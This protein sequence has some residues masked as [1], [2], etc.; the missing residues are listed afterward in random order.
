MAQI[1]PALAK[2]C[3]L[4]GARAVLISGAV[5]NPALAAVAPWVK[6]VPLV[7]AIVRGHLEAADVA[8]APLDASASARGKCA[9]KLLQFAATGLPVVGSPTDAN[10][11]ALARFDGVAVRS[12]Q[13][14]VDGLVQV[15]GEPAEHRAAR[16]NTALRAVAEHYSFEAWAPAGRSTTSLSRIARLT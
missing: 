10:A 1:A 15:L 4:A 6:R 2:V 7:P 9:H 8:I 16:G 5:D 13:E 14:W 11:F 3:E 12:Q